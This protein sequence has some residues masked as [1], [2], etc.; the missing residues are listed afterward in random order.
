MFVTLVIKTVISH[1]M[2]LLFFSSGP[3][4][5]TYLPTHAMPCFFPSNPAAPPLSSTC[6]SNC[7]KTNQNHVYCYF[8]L[9]YVRSVNHESFI[10][11]FQRYSY[12]CHAEKH[13]NWVKNNG[14]LIHWRQPLLSYF[15]LTIFL[16]SDFTKLNTKTTW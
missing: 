14:F 12:K 6:Q 10:F 9:F 4:T 13:W 7:F 11:N 15:Y 3:A 5:S 2:F 1:L 8:S 16:H